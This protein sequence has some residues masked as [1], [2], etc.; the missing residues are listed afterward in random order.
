MVILLLLACM[1]EPEVEA[2][3]T[4]MDPVRLLSRLSLDL[5]GTRPSDD[6]IARVEA[7]AAALDDLTAELLQDERFEERVRDLF[8]EVYLTRTESFPVNAASF[9]LGDEAAFDEAVGEEPL[10]IIGRVAAEDL[11]YTEVVLADWTMANGLL[12]EILPLELEGEGS[13]WQ[14]AS[15][16]DGR[17]PAGVLATTGL[18]WRYTS[19]DSNAN[20][21]RANAVSR[22]LL[23]ND[24]LSRPITFARDLDLLDEEAVQNAI[25]TD[26]SCVNCHNSLD[27]IASYLFGFWWYQENSALEISRYHPEREPLWSDYTEVTPGWYG[28][29][30]SSLTDLAWQIAA[31]PRYPECAVENVTRLMLRRSMDLQDAERLE[32]H[33]V[34]FLEGGLT[35][36]ALFASVV[37][38]PA[39]RAAAGSDEDV[40]G[41]APTKMLTPDQLGA[42]IAD[43]TGF[44]WTY[45]GYDMLG[46][47]GVGVR[48][49]AG[50]VDG[51]NVT[52]FAGSPNATVLLVQERLAEAAASYAVA[53]EQALAAG[54]RRLFTEIDFSET[55]EKGSDS[56]N[57]Q[58][59]ALQ[60]RVHGRRVAL[61]SEEVA[62]N[63]ALWDELYAAT[64]SAPESW[65]GLL[66]AL[67]R[68][69]DFLFY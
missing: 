37:A 20:R 4:E 53:T 35:L 44:T 15:Y 45:G 9:G 34:A 46:T 47:D 23:C 40:V 38:D 22:I 12:A 24:Y 59:Q 50:G 63:R 61:D 56:I 41:A 64:G 11:P 13:D 65:S 17:P 42:S 16:T 52:A 31:D 57:A 55:P 25:R 62:A 69:P 36:R 39:Y 27:P 7:D 26:A 14:R 6:E 68:D 67:L 30:G 60:L 48:T 58:I 49:L 54:E 19:T 32:T 29:A 66:S 1:P 28:E 51:S 8:S 18:W 3:S 33:R 5:R 43:L 21:R 2:P 10:R